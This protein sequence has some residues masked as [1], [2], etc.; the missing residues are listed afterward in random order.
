MDLLDMMT[1]RDDHD[2]SREAAD[3]IRPI[4]GKIALAVLEFA[5]R[6]GSYGFT[7]DELKTAHPEAP[8]SSYRKRRTE[9]TR[10]GRLCD[11]GERRINRHGRNE[12]VW[13]ISF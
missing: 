13:K 4:T 10:L 3:S 8:E 9:L 1:R 6:R 7:D 12:I 11:S 5:M 2:T